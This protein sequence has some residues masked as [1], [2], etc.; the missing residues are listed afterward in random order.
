MNANQILKRLG[1]KYTGMG[2][3][4]RAVSVLYI[5]PRVLSNKH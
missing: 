2:A 3:C 4:D 1:L 5:T